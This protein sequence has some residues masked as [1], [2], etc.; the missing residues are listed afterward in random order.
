[1]PGLTHLVSLQQA[2]GVEAH[3]TEFVERARVT[4][5][6][7]QQSWLNPSRT[8]HP[9]FA[10][11]LRSALAYTARAKY[12][13]PMKLPVRPRAL[14]V[15]H[16]RH[17]LARA[18]TDVLV[19]W[20]RSAKVLYALDAAGDARCVHWEHGA[21]WDPG[22]EHDRRDYF[23]RIR[24]AIANSRASA[25][26]LQLLWGYSGDVRICRNALRPS[27]VPA[28]PVRK[29]YPAS[30]IKLGVAARLYP[31]KGVAIAL[32]ALQALRARGCD[33][34]LHVAG[35]GP[36]L[37]GLQALARSLGI[38]ERVTF[39]GA[40]RDMEQFYRGIDCLLHAPLTEAFGLV[41]LEAASLG[42]PVIAAAVDGLPE[43]VADGVSGYSVVP[44]LPLAEY[45]SLGGT[46][47]GLP[48][49]VYDPSRD[50]L[51][52]TPLVDPAALADAVTRLFASAAAFEAMSAS[53]SAHVLRTSD[54][55]RH[56]SDVMAV[57]DEARR[58]A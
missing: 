11:R 17:A 9:F 1:V 5:P 51:V 16:A 13:G 37:Q 28:A 10:A 19:I 48:E 4:H 27:L 14:R 23:S 21:A 57:I 49:R 30:T 41:A 31:V 3:F 47:A 25:R 43:A 53:A 38:A 32:H 54:F 45:A 56:V 7:W 58:G 50:A 34:E 26:V 20:N 36:E 44:T 39:H 40:L 29:A 52:A 18:R 42:C 2:A 24:L 8:L 15:R 55:D 22:H 12:V 46:H 35:A 33:A 6:D